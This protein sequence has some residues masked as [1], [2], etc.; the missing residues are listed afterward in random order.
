MG[1]VSAASRPPDRPGK[2]NAFHGLV[3]N[4]YSLKIIAGRLALGDW[5]RALLSVLV[6]Q[7]VKSLPAKQE[8]QVRSWVGKILWRRE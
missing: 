8:T 4:F 5:V 1:T 7:M 6:A 3:D 2:V